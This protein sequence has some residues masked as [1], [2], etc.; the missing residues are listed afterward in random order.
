[1]PGSLRI[2]L[3]HSSL[4]KALTTAVETGLRPGPGGSDWGYDV[5]LDQ[6][7]LAPGV[8]WPRYLHE[9]MAR[10]HAAVLL[11]T[12]NA[13]QSE[14]VLKEATILTWR[15]SLD[16]Q[17]K[18]FVARFSDVS[19]ALLKQYRFT[20]LFLTHWQALPD[21]APDAII[22]SVR[23]GLGQPEPAATL[24]ETLAG[25]LGDVLGP[26]GLNTLKEV[27]AKLDVVPSKFTWGEG[28]RAQY[29][30]AVARHLVC[31][32]LGT[33]SGVGELADVLSTASGNVVKR[34]LQ[35]VEPYWVEAATA[36]QLPPILKSP[37]PRRAAGMNGRYLPQFTADMVVRK[38]HLPSMAQTVIPISGAWDGNVVAHVTREIADF[39]RTRH[40]AY[41]HF[42]DAQIVAEMENSEPRWYAV[43]PAAID[44]TSLGSLID[45][46]PSVAFVLWTGE[47]LVRHD[48]L[49]RVQWLEP[50]VDVQ[51]EAAAFQS[52]TAAD[53]IIQKLS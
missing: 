25:R 6:T 43:L 17:F 19:D 45:M 23:T 44:S 42:T 11:L 22:N 10:C 12:Q 27:A 16:P 36:A 8:E 14:W 32:V 24:F 47:H 46:F 2:F 30:D 29:V 4:D 40:K 52:S 3:S 31:G 28:E 37:K 9:W 34:I 33:F 15:A 5:L 18:L 1:M 53:E 41:T 7:D 26:V 49:A 39:M 35:L 38:A 48:S 51:R 50:P 21:S 13:V 20:P